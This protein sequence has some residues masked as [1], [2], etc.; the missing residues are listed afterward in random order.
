MFSAPSQGPLSLHPVGLA[1]RKQGEQSKESNA[2]R[3]MPS[4]ISRAMQGSRLCEPEKGVGAAKRQKQRALAPLAAPALAPA[5]APPMERPHLMFS[6]DWVPSPHKHD[7]GKGK[8][9]VGGAAK[10][11]PSKCPHQRR[12]SR[13]KECGGSSICPHQRRR[14]HCQECLH[15]HADVRYKGALLNGCLVQVGAFE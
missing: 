8:E 12:R 1:Q 10:K 14:S 4:Q 9:E 7:G 2:R 6:P 3:A 13:C 11:Q 15:T 5:P